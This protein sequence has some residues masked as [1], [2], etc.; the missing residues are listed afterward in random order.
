MTQF[1]QQIVNGLG[2]G[3]TYAIF[4]MGFS[5]V[6]ATLNVLNLAH[7]TY[8]TWGALFAYWIVEDFNLPIYLAIPIAIVGGGIIAVIVDRVG[9]APFRKP[10]ASNYGPVITSIAFMIILNNLALIATGARW[11][12]FP[13]GTFPN[14]NVNIGGIVIPLI[15]LM[16]F[17]I[18]IFIGIVLFFIVQKSRIGATMRAVGWNPSLTAI[19]GVNPQLI[20]IFTSFLGG[21]VAALAGILHGIST[22]NISFTLGD[23]LFFKGFAAVVLGGFGDYRG[24][25]IAGLFIGVLEVLSAQYISN[26]FKDAITFGLVLI[27]LLLL[28]KGILGKMTRRTA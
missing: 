23:G 7:G 27:I 8:A 26:S 12:S 10:G 17:I 16:N 1:L 18:A 28:P 13:A 6:F 5:L 15:I 22:N 2:I 14:Q 20:I 11:R 19:S 4:A 9:F 3:A 25:A 21:A 24:A